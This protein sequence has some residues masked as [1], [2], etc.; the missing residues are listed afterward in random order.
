MRHGR[1]SPRADDLAEK[2]RRSIQE[3]YKISTGTEQGFFGEE[4]DAVDELDESREA[5]LLALRQ[6][7]P[8][9]LWIALTTLATILVG[10]SYLVGMES[11][12]LHLLAV[13]ALATGIVLV[14]FTI[15][16]LDRPFR[17]DFRVEPQPFESVLHEIEGT[18]G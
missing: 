5:R 2:L 9:I 6:R 3:G 11:R 4:L 8:S 12:M 7:L 1:T 15:G 13:A 10:F 16:V 17:T 14:L 18:G